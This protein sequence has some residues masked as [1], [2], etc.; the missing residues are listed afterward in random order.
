MRVVAVTLSFASIALASTTFTK[1]VAPILYFAEPNIFDFE[2]RALLVNSQA[3]QTPPKWP[4]L[5]EMHSLT[6]CVL[7]AQKCP[8]RLGSAV[9]V[10]GSLSLRQRLLVWFYK[11]ECQEQTPPQSCRRVL[12]GSA[13][14][15]SFARCVRASCDGCLRDP[16]WVC[17]QLGFRFRGHANFLPRASSEAVSIP[18]T[19]LSLPIAWVFAGY[20]KCRVLKRHSAE[21]VT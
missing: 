4:I 13:F 20:A 15:P 16:I 6:E 19:S 10:A 5:R 8:T 1:D 11:R 12:L 17:R 9:S 18:R 3:A 14:S 7:R 2:L 21:T